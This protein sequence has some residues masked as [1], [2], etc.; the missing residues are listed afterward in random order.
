MKTRKH[1]PLA[2]FCWRRKS[3]ATDITK[4]CR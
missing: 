2:A 4:G 3:K 1:K